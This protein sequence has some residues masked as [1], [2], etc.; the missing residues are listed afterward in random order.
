MSRTRLSDVVR[1]WVYR[2]RRPM[3]PAR[4][5]YRQFG[6]LEYEQRIAP[7]VLPGVS[8]FESGFLTGFAEDADPTGTPYAEYNASSAMDPNNSM[9][10]VQAGTMVFED[11]HSNIL[12]ATTSNGGMSWTGT[13]VNTP[14]GQLNANGYSFPVD[15][16]YTWT[17]SVGF[18]RDGRVYVAYTHTNATQTAGRLIVTSFNFTNPAAQTHKVVYQWMDRDPAFNPVVGVNNNLPTYTDPQTGTTWRDP[19]NNRTLSPGVPPTPVY[20]AWNGNGTATTN[21]DNLGPA[22]VFDPNA[23]FVSSTFDRGTSFSSPLT[24]NS[25]GYFPGPAVSGGAGPQILFTPLGSDG[26]GRLVFLWNRMTGGIRYDVTQP[27]KVGGNTANSLLSWTKTA[28]GAAGGIGDAITNPAGGNDIPTTTTLLTSA[29]NLNVPEFSTLTD[30]TVRLAVL[31]NVTSLQHYRIQ[32][33]SPTGAKSVTLMNNAIDGAGAVIG[34]PPG[35][36]FQIGLLPADTNMGMVL[37]TDGTFTPV[38][39]AWDTTG[40]VSG[41]TM[42]SDRGARR[43]NDPIN[44]A[45]YVGLYRPESGALTSTFSS[46]SAANLSG[47]WKLQIT[48]VRSDGTPPAPPPPRFRAVFGW[49]VQFTSRTVNGFGTDKSVPGAATLP[50]G[51]PINLP[52][53]PGLGTLPASPPIQPSNVN[54]NPILS[55]SVGIGPGLS[56]AVDNSLG[57]NSPTHGNVYVAWTRPDARAEPNSSAANAKTTNTDVVLK[58]AVWDT[59][60]NNFAWGKTRLINN[61]S[62][63]DNMTEGLRTQFM[64]A[65]AVDN[66]NGTL[67]ATWYDARWDASNA[68][69][70]RY[71]GASIDG[72]ASFS[73][74]YLNVPHQAVDAITNQT[75][76]LEPTADNLAAA[77]YLA[78]PPVHGF[79]MNQSVV[80]Y[81]GKAVAFW[82]GNQDYNGSNILTAYGLYAS[83]PRVLGSDMGSVG[84]DLVV[85]DQNGEALS[86]NPVLADGTRQLDGFRITF[87]RPIQAGSFTRN[88]I[89]VMFR[90]P[91]TPSGQYG[92]AVPV[93][94]PIPLGGEGVAVPD[95]QL[96]SFF[97]PFLTPQT[98]VGTYSYAVGPNVR[99]WVQRTDGR[100]VTQRDANGNPIEW[101]ILDP[102]A[103]EEPPQV[104]LLGGTRPSAFPSN[105]PLSSFGQPFT[106][107]AL[108]LPIPDNTGA[109]SFS[110][111]FVP[112]LPAGQVI[113]EIL[114]D[115]NITHPRVADLSKGDLVV[116]LISP[117]GQKVHLANQMVI[118]GSTIATGPGRNFNN[119]RFDVRATRSL[120]SAS[121]VDSPGFT[122][123]WRPV[124][125]SPVPGGFVTL[126]SLFGTNPGAGNWTL[127][128]QDK[129]TGNIGTFDSWSISILPGRLVSATNPSTGNWLDQNNDSRP[130]QLPSIF[131]TSND[132]HAVPKP[133]NGVPFLL[134]YD[135]GTLPLVLGGARM[136]G[137]NAPGDFPQVIDIV[138]NL[139]P[140]PFGTMPVLDVTF[141]RLVDPTTFD[142]DGRDILQITPPGGP[143][144]T[145]PFVVA[146][147]SGPTFRI[148]LPNANF[149]AGAYARTSILFAPG[150]ELRTQNDLTLNGPQNT[151]RLTFD[152]PMDPATFTAADIIKLTGPVGDI[153]L[154]K[155]PP[156]VTPVAGDAKSFDVGFPTQVLSGSYQF[157]LSP[158]I[159]SALGQAVDTDRDGGLDVLRGIDPNAATFTTITRA[160]PPGAVA[161]TP[162]GTVS[163]PLN[164]VDD[165]QIKQLI[166]SSRATSKLISVR[167]NITFPNDP[168]LQAD[169][170]A[171][172][173]ARVRLF[174]GVG[175]LGIP[176][177]ANFTNTVLDDLGTTPIQ[178]A[179]PPFNT[180][181]YLPQ[182]PLSALNGVGSKGS[183]RLEVT[184][185]S[186]RTGQIVDWS[187]TLPTTILGTGLG[188]PVSDRFTAKFRIFTQDPTIDLTQK[189]WTSVGAEPVN[190][191][192]TGNPT[193][194]GRVNAVAVDPSDPSGNTV[195]VG[196]AT[197]GVWKTTNFLTLD[198]AGPVWMPLTD[199]GSTFSL[200]IANILLIPINNDPN[201]TMVFALT[202]AGGYPNGTNPNPTTPGT[203]VGGVG[204]LRSADGGKTWKIL[205][206]TVNADPAGNIYPIDAPTGSGA[207]QRDRRFFNAN[208]FK[209]IADPTPLANGE[210]IL[211]MAVGGGAN[212]RGLWRSTDTGK[213]WVR[214]NQSQLD[215]DATDVVLGA[216]S[217]GANGNLTRLYA[218]FQGRGV[219]GV[220]T[221]SQ[222][223]SALSLS[224][225]AGQDGNLLIRQ[226]DEA[227]PVDQP[228]RTP[229]G[230]GGRYVIAAPAVTNSPLLNSFYRDWLYVARVL[231]DGTYDG[232]WMTKDFGRNWVDIRLPQYTDPVGFIHGTND[233]SRADGDRFQDPRRIP[234]QLG[235]GNRTLSLTVSPLNPNIVYLGGILGAR[236]DTTAVNDHM[237]FTYYEYTDA[238]TGAVVTDNTIGGAYALGPNATNP[239]LLIPGSDRAVYPTGFLNLERDPF[240]PFIQNAT[241]RVK[242]EVPP[243][244]PPLYNTVRFSNDGQDVQWTPFYNLLTIGSGNLMFSDIT[245][246]TPFVDPVTGK[247]RI[248]AG[249]RYGIVS[250]V[251]NGDVAGTGTISPGIGFSRLPGNDRNGTLQLE[252][253]YSGAVQPSVLASDVAGALF[254]GMS[255]DNGYMVS[256][257][258]ILQTGDLNWLTE[259]GTAEPRNISS[260]TGIGS[261]ADLTGTGSA[262]QYRLPC[263]YQP[264]G[265]IQPTDYFRVF[266]PGT[267]H[268]GPGVS[269]TNGLLQGFPPPADDPANDVGQWPLKDPS[270]G[271][272]T[273]NPIDPNGIVIGSRSGQV[274]RT[275]DKGVQWTPIARPG[276]L[277]G[278]Y[279][280]ALAYGAPNP[281][282]QVPGLLNNFIYA[283]T[284][285]G[286]VFV[287]RVGD[288]SWR[289]ISAG[290]APGSQLMQIVANPRRGSRDAFAVTR[291]AVYYIADSG[292][293]ADNFATTTPWVDITANLFQLR[294][295]VFGDQNTQ[296]IGPGGVNT[297]LPYALK[298]LQTIV[299]DW[300]YAIPVDPS[301]P[302]SPTYPVLYVAGDGG[303]VRSINALSSV[304]TPEWTLFP[305]SSVFS[306]PVAGNYNIPTGGYLPAGLVTDLDF[307]IGNISTLD[308]QPQSAGALNLL[309]ATTW[310][311]GTWAIRPEVP[312]AVAQ[313]LVTGNSGARVIGVATTNSTNTLMVRFDEPVDPTKFTPS[314]VLLK[315]PGGAV[316]PVTSV[317]PVVNSF[318]GSLD[319]RN[320]FQLTFPDQTAQGF[321]TLVIGPF[322]QDFAG[323]PMN[324]DGDITN[325][326]TAISYTG[327][328]EDA[329]AGL[330]YLDPTAGTVGN[331]FIDMPL[332]TRAGDPTPVT[333]SAAAGTQVIV[334]GAPAGNPDAGYDHVVR[335]ATSDAFAQLISFSPAP[336]FPYDYQ[337]TNQDFGSRTFNFEFHT[338]GVQTVTVTDLDS[339]T[340]PNF[341]PAQASILVHGGVAKY[342]QVTGFPDPTTAGAPGP[343]TVI[344]RDNF[345]T[346]ANGFLGNVSDLY[347]GT[348]TFSTTDP[349]VSIGNGLPNNYTFT[350]T[351]AGI[352]NFSGLTLKT[353]GY[354]DIRVTDVNKAAITGAQTKIKVNPAVA[355]HLIMSKIVPNP[356]QAGTAATFT[357]TAEDKYNNIATGYLGTL[358][359]ASDDKQ[360]AP[361]S[362]L[363]LDYT[364]VPADAGVHAFG[365]TFKTAGLKTLTATDTTNFLL[366]ASQTALVTP[367]AAGSFSVSGFPNPTTAGIP[368]NFQVTAL[369]P[370]GNVATGYAGTVHFT[371]TDPQAGLPVDYKFSGANAGQ[372]TFTA[373]L[374]TS[375]LQSITATDTVNAALTG[376]QSGIVVV[377]AAA[378]KF[379][380]TDLPPTATAGVQVTFTL[381]AKDPFGN[382]ATG[383]AGLVRFTNTD[384]KATPIPDYVFVASD[385]GVRQFP[386]TFKTAGLQTVTAFDATT[387]TMNAS[388]ST[389]VSAAGM[390]GFTLS[391]LPN[392]TTAGVPA[393][394]TVAARDAF[395]NTITGYTGTVHFTSSDPQVA[396][397]DGLPADYTF[398]GADNGVHTFNGGATLKTAGTQTVV[399]TDTVNPSFTGGQATVVTPTVASRF[400]VTGFPSPIVTGTAG[401]FTVTARDKFG[402]VATGYGGLVHFTSSDPTVSAGK[403]LP[404]NYPFQTG[405]AGAHTFSATLKTVGTQSITA[406]DVNN[407]SITGTQSGIEVVPVPPPPP[408]NPPTISDVTNV[409]VPFNGSAGPILFNVGDVETPV[410]AL[411]VTASSTNAG[412]LPVSKITFGGSGA[413]R[414]VTLTPLTG[415]SGTSV[416]T[417]TVTDGAGATATDTFTVTVPLP[418]GPPPPPPPPPGPPGPPPPPPP[419]P[420]GPPPP[421]I[422]QGRALPSVTAVGTGVGAGNLVDVYNADGSRLRQFIP[423]AQ[424][425]TGGTRTAIARTPD[426]DRLLVAPGPGTTTDVL[427]FDLATGNL[428]QIFQPFE[429]SFTGG[430]FVAAGDIDGD[431]FD[432]TVVT[433]DEGGG[434]RVR[435]FSG[436]DGRTVADFLGIEDPEFRGGAR[437]AVG[438]VN[439][440]GHQ[441]LVVAAGFGGGPRVAI[442]DGGTV[443]SNRPS[444]L[445]ADFFVFEQTLRNGVYVA[446]GDVNGDGYAELIVGGGPGGGPRV[447]ALD[448]QS[449]AKGDTSRVV[450]NFF[451]GNTENR[452]GI[453]IAVKNLDGDNQA[454]LVV[455]DGEGAGSHVTSY[456]GRVLVT[457][458]TPAPIFSFDEIPGFTGGVFVG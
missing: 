345:K 276:E 199:L 454:D 282:D 178:T 92:S 380:M 210:R 4:R 29:V 186:F 16:T 204:I 371:S 455:G 41:G 399:A 154:S 39:P 179:T 8:V 17:P 401:K 6:L 195:Y 60:S 307:S 320:L 266:D 155:T 339:G 27:D 378:T 349:Q 3:K 112:D 387:Q 123:A 323:R 254:Y 325:G 141:D 188:E 194:S 77:D 384:T 206:S 372:Q 91:T 117:T 183:W 278:T 449:L 32:L 425:F 328:A 145:G 128:V 361:G 437:A 137:V 443:P 413:N 292:D 317:T 172:S 258:N 381:T 271:Y 232:L 196:G 216:G 355:D 53:G 30:I 411:T 408:N 327:Y 111:I 224:I 239:G 318:G 119:T 336:P 48:D 350:P 335:L 388:Q 433:P 136:V 347:G 76:T 329:Y 263:C 247:V 234:S 295:A 57:V 31:N 417:L 358:T 26:V 110:D 143:A 82:S 273:V 103:T 127:Q 95:N 79:G 22:D 304:G 83:G 386:V 122:G 208:G 97:V 229:N 104:P 419:G 138:R 107:G 343:I 450:F 106:S 115:V 40:T 253:F 13:V 205:D 423:Y 383:Y 451:A 146:H 1:R 99:D 200:N 444:R 51:L 260:S 158:A 168:D 11:G 212:Q 434:P 353:V 219:D 241:L 124:L 65:L 162:F 153:D 366:F 64:P 86:F 337:F 432:D 81:D 414:T 415:Q 421:P 314:D 207:G 248:L 420:P 20:V 90:N 197:G 191:L 114:V 265:V 379:F 84:E 330:V 45:P 396:V 67:V 50:T 250:G 225:M 222:A 457:G 96:T 230:G 310:G 255:Q 393:S 221:T 214:V 362:G 309:V 142:A 427:V 448:G 21:R 363:P 37:S 430:M 436:A 198:P 34:T 272:F 456:P 311:R 131:P 132:V 78:G 98:A 209:I 69:V 442:F 302:N 326:E 368:G 238:V 24:V 223:T 58:P 174:T 453:R 316:I 61:D 270:I 217:F 360:I 157:E 377:A 74:V 376:T 426:G 305:E 251:D 87:D 23:I 94:D 113:G 385:G 422:P 2:I 66:A 279:V 249:T 333:V 289:D 287:T 407:S 338:A 261:A 7:A 296:P 412:L 354:Q 161:I 395:G 10:I 246:M 121:T 170:V 100:Y 418:P 43:I 108:G 125:E 431:G 308:G 149:P 169:L 19:L 185:N 177:L 300:R 140:P 340:G 446:S 88:D 71:M 397:G 447:M 152:R 352:H 59:A 139:V 150:A 25:G 193:N 391:G 283:G 237:K 416:V 348:I 175:T 277:D 306:D 75:V 288:G 235:V 341:N 281:G 406:T 226:G 72:G 192:S 102:V 259:I 357:V 46:L 109:S 370:F 342:F 101:V 233:T 42:F 160:T 18:G 439:G 38:V 105:P 54:P 55:P 163:L 129:V 156:T 218:V 189:V 324:Q 394:F 12:L 284:T 452:G 213:S 165:F 359:F 313:Y 286:S 231:G 240:N 269:R 268:F 49:S 133:T 303:V 409:T 245:S 56:V 202:G 151:V 85:F 315:A 180:G 164:V 402:N 398:T 144:L 367:A 458:V 187:L 215:G 134:P 44:A 256:R 203:A 365:V 33:V 68:R 285:G 118:N 280:R 171:P 135:T 116:T 274:F 392:P 9:N 299:A 364:Y 176:P 334:N 201:Q 438:D 293:P 89:T 190:R 405:D 344:A 373:N 440:D 297:N 242:D 148:Y 264:T 319:R 291:D 130:L 331:L 404:V 80:A 374:K 428:V 390:A 15:L 52:T 36:P 346:A 298:S 252:Q 375:G 294:K 147:L 275:Q 403:G 126:Q 441:D 73:Q 47:Q 35:A 181:P 228:G 445:V 312:P 166:T 400:D 243:D 236:I 14:V 410:S 424:T 262:Y 290:I 332:A 173:G 351:D 321:Y 267:S 93:G 244:A 369:D 159:N 182:F 70:S 301:D 389:M 167:L 62:A 257:S 429:P 211:Y 435:I 5:N 184:N 120:E 63:S 220:Y 28:V 356:V 322:V 382:N 227:V